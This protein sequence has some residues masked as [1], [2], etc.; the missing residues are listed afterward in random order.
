MGIKTKFMKSYSLRG[1]WTEAR[2]MIRACEHGFNVS[3]PWGGSSRYDF[4]LELNGQFLRVQVKSTTWKRN[5]T[6][7]VCTLSSDGCKR[8]TEKEI[9]FFAIY[10]IPEDAWY[11]IPASVGI[12]LRSGLLLY[13]HCTNQ[14]KHKY[15]CYFE[16]WHLLKSAKPK[17]K[18]ATSSGS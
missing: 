12:R 16:A 4:A 18:S 8:Y 10:V 7:Y 5:G 1:E 3:R 15:E 14:R 17:A 6:G 13:P 11:I 9:D 2:F